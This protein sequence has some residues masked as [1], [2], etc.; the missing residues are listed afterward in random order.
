M[1]GAAVGLDGQ[2]VR[3]RVGIEAVTAVSKDQHTNAEDNPECKDF[4]VYVI[5]RWSKEEAADCDNG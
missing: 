2:R 4:L 1:C 5:W 3:R